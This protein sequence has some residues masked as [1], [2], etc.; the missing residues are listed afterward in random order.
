MRKNE[1]LS[2]KM[3]LLLLIS[4]VSLVFI[5]SSRYMS[6]AV[7]VTKYYLLQFAISPLPNILII[8]EY[9]GKEGRRGRKER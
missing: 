3:H 4:L 2:R 1:I 5:G 6:R 7:S 9:G 8:K